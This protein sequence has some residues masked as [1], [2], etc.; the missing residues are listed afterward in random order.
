[1]CSIPLLLRSDLFRASANIAWWRNVKLHKQ[2]F[3]GFFKLFSLTIWT[4]SSFDTG[5]SFL[6]EATSFIHVVCSLYSVL[7]NY[8][9]DIA[10]SNQLPLRKL[11]SFTLLPNLSLLPPGLASQ[12]AVQFTPI[13]FFELNYHQESLQTN[14]IPFRTPVASWLQSSATF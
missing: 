7:Y 3:L 11:F 9:V 13:S 6:V 12:R 14:L 4:T 2:K 10:V 8:F 5:I 1:M